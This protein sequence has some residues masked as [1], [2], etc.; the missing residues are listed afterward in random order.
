[1]EVLIGPN[2]SIGM[3]LFGELL[4][5]GK[6]QQNLSHLLESLQYV[7][8]L[9]EA[10]YIVS[11][12]ITS[13]W[14]ALLVKD[15]PENRLEDIVDSEILRALVKYLSQYIDYDHNGTFTALHYC[16]QNNKAECVRVLV[17]C[18]ADVNVETTY[19]LFPRKTAL[20]SAARAKLNGPLDLVKEGGAGE[21]RHWTA[22]TDEVINIL[23][24]A[25][26]KSGSNVTSD[27]FIIAELTRNLTIHNWI[28]FPGKIRP[29]FWKG[30]FFSKS[31]LHMYR[32]WSTDVLYSRMH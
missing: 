4:R 5:R 3:T 18:G 12:T 15:E 22:K 6:D 11:G 24:E 2:R 13:V 8:N 30:V 20:D 29:L 32:T 1:M 7:A 9:R 31:A 26:G 28:K 16:T 27:E 23:I 10:H 19:P 17:R 21:I 14:L 25:R